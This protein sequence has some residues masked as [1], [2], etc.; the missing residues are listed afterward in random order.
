MGPLLAQLPLGA[1]IA[2]FPL[3]STSRLMG[4]NGHW[5]GGTG[6][7]AWNQAEGLAEGA[8]LVKCVHVTCLSEILGQD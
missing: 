8:G 2:V 4:L 3:P 1:G 6:R 7:K 5:D